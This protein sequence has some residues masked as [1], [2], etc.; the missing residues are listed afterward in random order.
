MASFER[1]QAE[2]RPKK[3]HRSPA[4]DEIDDLVR[5]VCG[6]FLFG[7]PLLYTMEVWWVGSSASPPWLLLILLLTFAVVYLI[8]RTEGF[9]KARTASER[10]AVASTVE[11]VAIGLVCAAITLIVL[12]QVTLQT[13]LSGAIGQIV[14]ESVPFSLGVALANQ[15]LGHK[16]EP[17]KGEQEAENSDAAS[18]DTANSEEEPPPEQLFADDDL[19][20]TIADIGAT[21]IGAMVIA[22][23]IAPTDEVPVLV[24]AVEDS[25]LILIVMVS[26]ILSYCIVFQAN[27]TQQGERRRH[28]GWFQKPLSE[29]LFAYLISLIAAAFMLAFFR[30]IDFNTPWDLA[31]SHIL[32]LGLP[33]TIGGAAGRL[34]L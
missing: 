14:F 16:E 27:F 18:S 30:Q 6:A 7:A 12:R 34:T 32:I 11:A 3:R 22:L 2:N 5:G 31:F 9:R 23:S 21:L 1:Y 20:A 25:W 13:N 8:N 28:R 26:L 19:N 17:E 29:T 24:A 10:E 33:A 15:F 4:R